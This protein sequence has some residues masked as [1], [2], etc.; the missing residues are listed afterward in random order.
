MSRTM[1]P[2]VKSRRPVS[3]SPMSHPAPPDY[4]IL[5]YILYDN[6]IKHP[7]ILYDSILYC[8][9]PRK[10]AAH[11]RPSLRSPA[12]DLPWAANNN[13]NTNNTTTTTTTTTTATNTNRNNT[14]TNSNNYYNKHNLPASAGPGRLRKKDAASWCTTSNNGRDTTI[15]RII[16]IMLLI[17]I[18]A[19][20]P[21]LVIAINGNKRGLVVQ[22]RPLVG[23][24]YRRVRLRF[25]LSLFIYIAWIYLFQYLFVVVFF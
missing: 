12:C 24:G 2:S 11:P 7:V 21:P 14:P 18:A 5:H 10:T 4:I 1:C 6:I 3:D 22:H 25:I 19:I 9:L 20:I 17:V 23:R 16:L 13:N 8:I 15:I